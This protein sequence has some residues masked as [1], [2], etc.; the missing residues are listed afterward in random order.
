MVTVLGWKRNLRCLGMAFVTGGTI[1][2]LGEALIWWILEEIKIFYSL[3]ATIPLSFVFFHN[4]MAKR[5][6]R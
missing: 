1:F 4:R 6:R 5:M 2:V 3:I